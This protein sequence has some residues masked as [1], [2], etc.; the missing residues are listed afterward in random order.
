M[1]SEMNS[2]NYF[3]NKFSFL[4]KNQTRRLSYRKKD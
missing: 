3:G 4:K 2:D 1:N